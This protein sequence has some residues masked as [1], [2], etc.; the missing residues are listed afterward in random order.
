M[1]VITFMLYFSLL[2]IGG[3]YSYAGSQS[4]NN[5][6]LS[7]QNF[8]HKKHI[9]PT[10]EDQSIVVIEDSDVDFEEDFFANDNFNDNCKTIFFGGK[11]DLINTMYSLNSRQLAL[12]NCE[13]YCEIVQPS[14]V[15]SCP[16]YLSQKVL[17][18]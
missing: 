3:S 2:L 10:I 4:G 8:A 11:Y 16:I 13:K 5:V 18:I 9:K 1:R 6:N 7:L 17:R 15:N 12:F 14:R